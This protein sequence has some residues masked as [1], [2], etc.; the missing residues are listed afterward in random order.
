MLTGTLDI[1]AGSFDI[2]GISSRHNQRPLSSDG[3]RS[4]NDGDGGAK[5]PPLAR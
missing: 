4:F 5:R 3:R 2:A 1:R